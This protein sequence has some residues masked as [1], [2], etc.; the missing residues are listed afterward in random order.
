[1]TTAGSSADGALP[2]PE[3]F[4]WGASTAAYQVEG[5]ARADGRGPSIW[6]TFSHQ[7]GNVRGGDTGDI[8]CDSYYRYRE[9][10]ALLASFGLNAY[11][12]SISWPRVLPGGRGPV[13]Q[14]GLDYYRSLLDELSERNIAACVTLYHW[15]LPQELQDAGGC[16]PW[17]V[18]RWVTGS[19]SGS[20]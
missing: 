3:G 18:L 11:R 7:P 5:A 4:A 20:R 8:A 15:D 2:F 19:P 12:F 6:D 16:A 14:K 10:I 17:S 1:M 9:D 13:N